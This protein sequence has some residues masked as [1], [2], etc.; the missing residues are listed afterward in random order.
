MTTLHTRVALSLAAAVTLGALGTSSAQAGGYVYVGGSC[1]PSYCAPVYY[2][3]VVYR[4]PVYVAP[5]PVYYAPAPVVYTAPVVY[6]APVVYSAP[7]R[8]Y[9]PAYYY[10][11]CRSRGFSFSVGWGRHGRCW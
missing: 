4:A 9:R 5:A 6:R 3:P 1:G 2:P 8:V 7:V 11:T 10:P